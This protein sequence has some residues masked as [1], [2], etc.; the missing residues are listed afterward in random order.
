MYVTF[1][2]GLLKTRFIKRVACKCKR[3][4]ERWDVTVFAIKNHARAFSI[5][6]HEY[7]F[8]TEWSYEFPKHINNVPAYSPRKSFFLFR[9]FCLFRFVLF[10]FMARLQFNSLSKLACLSLFS[11]YTVVK[12]ETVLT[13][14]KVLS[15]KFLLILQ[16]IQINW[17]T[18]HLRTSE[19]IVCLLQTIEFL[20]TKVYY[21]VVFSFSANL[22]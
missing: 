7:E 8:D 14:T 5:Q 4:L 21:N 15:A 2:A 9:L 12:K 6:L 19:Y 1:I 17:M 10:L 3:G 20:D 11:L 18:L 22:I 16:L 13:S